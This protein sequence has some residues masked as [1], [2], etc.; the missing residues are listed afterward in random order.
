MSTT[1]AWKKFCFPVCYTYAQCLGMGNFSEGN[2]LVVQRVQVIAAL[3]VCDS[4]Y[5]SCAQL[6]SSSISSAVHRNGVYAL[7]RKKCIWNTVLNIINSI[8]AENNKNNPIHIHT[9]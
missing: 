9:Q 5:G 2:L 6:S 3:H 7:L 8:L 1:I 4:A